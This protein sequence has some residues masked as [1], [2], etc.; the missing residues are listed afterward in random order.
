[1]YSHFN[2]QQQIRVIMNKDNCNVSKM[3]LGDLKQELSVNFRNELNSIHSSFQTEFKEFISTAINDIL[4][5]KMTPEMHSKSCVKVP[6]GKKLFNR[7]ARKVLKP[8]LPNSATHSMLV[9]SARRGG[10]KVAPWEPGFN[11]NQTAPSSVATTVCP[12]PSATSLP[13]CEGIIMLKEGELSSSK[14]SSAGKQHDQLD[15]TKKPV[16][17]EPP[18]RLP[19][20]R[21]QQPLKRKKKPSNTADQGGGDSDEHKSSPAVVSKLLLASSSVGV[22]NK[23]AKELTSRCNQA[24]NKVKQELEMIVTPKNEEEDEQ[25]PPIPKKRGRP[26]FKNVKSESKCTAITTTA[27]PAAATVKM[28]ATNDTNIPQEIKSLPIE[29][30]DRC[31]E[32]FWVKFNIKVTNECSAIYLYIIY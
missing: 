17:S 30:R 15:H 4:I 23:D 7:K 3:T 22:N 2:M 1:M 21:G 31:M 16:E 25:V 24:N 14:K 8:P 29:I 11:N 19:N 27:T 9:K 12:L 28:G 18:Q 26:P 5:E 32:I 13:R 20:K 6:G 10:H